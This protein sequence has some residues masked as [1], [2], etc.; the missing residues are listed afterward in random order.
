M[1]SDPAGLSDSDNDDTRL[2]CL[3]CSRLRRR[4]TGWI[5]REF[6][7][8]Q[9]CYVGFKHCRG[10]GATVSM[11]REL[12]KGGGRGPVSGTPEPSSSLLLKQLSTMRRFSSSKRSARLMP[13]LPD[14]VA[15]PSV[16]NLRRALGPVGGV[17]ECFD[18]RRTAGEV[19]DGGYSRT[20]GQ[21]DV[22]N[23][24][25]GSGL[26][27]CSRYGMRPCRPSEQGT[28]GTQMPS[29]LVP[30]Y[31]PMWVAGEVLQPGYCVLHCAALHLFGCTR[32]ST[33]GGAETNP[34]MMAFHRFFAPSNANNISVRCTAHLD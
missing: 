26:K 13:G 17:P 14:M 1:Y 19:A 10:R 33:G 3:G 15:S 11:S 4:R 27:L 16:R 12:E 29:T 5:L 9:V 30:Q 32:S 7:Y 6:K 24:V 25:A 31:V 8:P 21:R 28:L 20:A 18:G 22:Q 23:D 34:E 2:F